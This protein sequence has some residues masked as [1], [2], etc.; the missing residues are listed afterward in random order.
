MSVFGMD[1][2]ATTYTLAQWRGFGYDT[3]SIQAADTA[4]FVT[5][6]TDF[7][8]KSGSPAINAGTTLADC[9]DDKDGNVPSAGRRVRHRLLRVRHRRRFP[10]QRQASRAARPARPTARLSPPQAA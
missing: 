9:T 8:L 1:D 7:H 3:H 5:P 4:L 6:G 2:N 10:S